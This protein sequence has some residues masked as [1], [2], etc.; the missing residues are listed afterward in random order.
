M[1]DAVILRFPGGATSLLDCS[2]ESIDRNRIELIGTRGTLEFPN[3]V[4][5]QGTSELIVRD[6]EREERFRFESIR[7]YAEQVAAFC[8]GIETRVLPDPAEDGL[9]NMRA[10]CETKRIAWASG[11]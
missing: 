1:T 4:L 11:Q 5:P 2:F 10:M 6:A 8:R 3:G 7:Q 9:A